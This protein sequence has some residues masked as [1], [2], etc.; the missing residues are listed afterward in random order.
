[1][2]QWKIVIF[3]LLYNIRKTCFQFVLSHLQNLMYVRHYKYSYVLGFNLKFFLGVMLGAPSI[4]VGAPSILSEWTKMPFPQV[5]SYDLYG[6]SSSVQIIRINLIRM[7][8]LYLR[9]T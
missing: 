2:Y 9:I 7:F 6:S 4:I 3:I 8:K 1:M 5:D